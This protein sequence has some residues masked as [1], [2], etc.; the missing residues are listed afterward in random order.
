MCL[1]LNE[2]GNV[3]STNESSLGIEDPASI[4]VP[5]SLKFWRKSFNNLLHTVQ[6]FKHAGVT[7]SFKGIRTTG[8]QSGKTF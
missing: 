4:V 1:L 6:A 2:Q 7:N 5:T 3:T 8:Q